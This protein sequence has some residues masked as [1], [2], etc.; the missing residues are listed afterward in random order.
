MG[1]GQGALPLARAGA[2][3]H[4]Y[5]VR[6]SYPLRIRFGDV[7]PAQIAFYPRFFEWFHE[8]FEAMFEEVFGETY[9][10]ILERKGVGYPTVQLAC[11]Y[12]QPVR[13]GQLVNIEV[14]LSRMSP[15]SATFEYRVR[16]E[17]TLHASASIKVAAM[18]MKS[19]KP[20]PWD[21]EILEKFANYI[22]LD[23]EKPHPEQIW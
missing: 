15:R 13:F 5:E 22:E 7:D 23:Q 19:Q 20:E 18:N 8:S 16:S 21:Q 4:T 10:Q 14:F 9:A 6:F 12:L 2:K 1:P 17:N 3:V 11:E